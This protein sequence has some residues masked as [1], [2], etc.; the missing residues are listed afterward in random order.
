MSEH[1]TSKS[2]ADQA[3]RPH[4]PHSEDVQVSSAP[5][6]RRCITHELP[7]A[8]AQPALA[9]KIQRRMALYDSRKPYR[10]EEVR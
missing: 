4:S 6:P 10:Q 1:E 5:E 2:I 9:E 7:M 3:N 8:Q